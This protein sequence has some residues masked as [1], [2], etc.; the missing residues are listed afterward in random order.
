MSSNE[1]VEAWQSN[2]GL[3]DRSDPRLTVLKEFAESI[4]AATAGRVTAAVSRGYVSN[5]GQEWRVVA[6]SDGDSAV[7]LLRAHLGADD[8]TQLDLYDEELETC[9]GAE[10][11]RERLK[12]FARS[13]AARSNLQVLMQHT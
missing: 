8:T 11:L 3:N 2:D 5:L 4:A 12:T 1:F 13:S 9:D 7:I 10:A 6:R